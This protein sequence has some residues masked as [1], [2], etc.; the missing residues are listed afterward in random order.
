MLKYMTHSK[1]ACSELS[2]TLLKYMGH[3]DSDSR[4][5]NKIST[6]NLDHYNVILGY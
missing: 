3:K 4:I 2:R 6:F 5:F 1:L